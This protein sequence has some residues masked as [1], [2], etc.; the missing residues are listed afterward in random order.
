MPD[1]PIWFVSYVARIHKNQRSLGI[2]DQKDSF[3]SILFIEILFS[4]ILFCLQFEFAKS[5][6][7]D[8]NPKKEKESNQ[9]QK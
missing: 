3:F 1:C 9:V 7:L 4:F 6:M 2:N 8:E 5:K